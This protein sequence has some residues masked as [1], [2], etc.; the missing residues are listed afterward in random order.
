MLIFATKWIK[1]TRAIWYT[2]TEL[3]IQGLAGPLGTLQ[4]NIQP[5][6]YMHA[7]RS[8]TFLSCPHSKEV[9]TAYT[10]LP[11]P[12]HLHNSL[13]IVG[14]ACIIFS[15]R[16]FAASWT[17]HLLGKSFLPVFDFIFLVMRYWDTNNFFVHLDTCALHRGKSL[18]LSQSIQAYAFPWA[19]F[20]TSLAVQESCWWDHSAHVT[21]PTHLQ[22]AGECFHV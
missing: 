2:L 8:S 22:D 10:F 7:I 20:E 15:N 11:S 1:E 17:L 19:R 6:L 16:L 9:R 13:M 18:S 21:L 4:R 5:W 14:F 12:S 3:S